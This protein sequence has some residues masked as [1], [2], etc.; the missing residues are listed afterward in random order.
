MYKLIDDVIL[1]L[2]DAKKNFSIESHCFSDSCLHQIY[3]D[4]FLS[5]YVSETLHTGILTVMMCGDI[6]K[7][8]FKKS[9]LKKLKKDKLVSMYNYFTNSH[10]YGYDMLKDD[11]IDAL[12][13][14]NI[15]TF[16]IFCV[17]ESN[18]ML[19]IDDEIYQYS[20]LLT[21]PFTVHNVSGYSQGDLAIVIDVAENNF[22]S[23]YL[24]NL[25]FDSPVTAEII[26]NDY[27]LND[28]YKFNWCDFGDHYNFDKDTFILKLK[29]DLLSSEFDLQ[30]Q[31]IILQYAGSN[32][33]DVPDYH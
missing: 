19:D 21:F 30:L 14:V 33:S 29:D 16:L 11:F 25:F 9:K 1:N 2:D 13:N 22:D 31:E 8:A 7:P 3:F 26:I 20:E 28:I 24:Q 6:K 10:S 27:D 32:I 17:N 5:E 18:R 4:D 12:E 23:N 15:E